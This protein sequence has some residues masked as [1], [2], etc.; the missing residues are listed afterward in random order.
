MDDGK[1][2]GARQLMG[3]QMGAVCRRWRKLIDKEL[4]P[5]GLTDA[6]WL[7]LLVIHRSPKPFLQKELAETICIESSTLVRLLDALSSSGIIERRP[8]S[9]R[10]AKL[11]RLTP[12]GQTVAA[13]VELA[14]D[15]VRDQVLRE[16][17]EAEIATVMNVIDKIG[18]AMTQ[19]AE[20]QPKKREL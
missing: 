8:D 13:A 4:R 3:I 14:V 7:P 2:L 5:F 12:H 11:I 10:R 17:S 19:I 20:A 15:A 16:V 6:T 18:F 9:D 1:H